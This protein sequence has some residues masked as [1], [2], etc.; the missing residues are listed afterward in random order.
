[1]AEHLLHGIST[2]LSSDIL[3]QT[4]ETV[5]KDREQIKASK[6]TRFKNAS[7]YNWENESK[8]LV[9]KWETILQ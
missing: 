6:I 3:S 2:F 8:A 9:K 1:M 4:F 5:L 7:M